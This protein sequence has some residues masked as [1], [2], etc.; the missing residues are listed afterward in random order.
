MNKVRIIDL[1]NKLMKGENMPK[2][3]RTI[4]DNQEFVYDEF[5]CDYVKNDNYL[6]E[7]IGDFIDTK[8]FLKEEIEIIEK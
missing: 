6:F 2:K 1:F 4:C 3:I 8:N 5:C 7:T